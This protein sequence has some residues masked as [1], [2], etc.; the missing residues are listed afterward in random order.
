[1]RASAKKKAYA[2]I[3]LAATALWP[4]S[5]RGQHVQYSSPKPETDAASWAVLMCPL[6]TTIQES[7]AQPSDIQKAAD[8]KAAL[9]DR[10]RF[11]ISEFGP[12]SWGDTRF[13][14]RP[15]AAMQ[16][17][18]RIGKPA[19]KPLIVV[20]NDPDSWRRGEAADVLG[21]IGDPRA[22][23]PLL[24]VLG[25]DRIDS[26]RAAAARA[27]GHIP[28]RRTTALLLQALNAMDPAVRRE[29]ALALGR[30]KAREAIAPLTQR[31]GD[32]GWDGRLPMETVGEAAATAIAGYGETG[33]NLLLKALTSPTSRVRRDAIHGLASRKDTRVIPVFISLLQDPD[34]DVRY[35]VIYWLGEFKDRRALEPL[36]QLLPDKENNDEY[37]VTDAIKKI[38]GKPL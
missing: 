32:R 18:V 31:F 23:T 35:A 30:R 1:M 7:G 37:Q 20:L 29:A 15:E 26:V 9:A 13:D 21:E 38:E 25:T 28:G 6:S 33:Y 2:L 11:L 17:L 12:T 14:P 3:G 27:L 4:V 36:R 10:I 19:V 22:I 8:N 16:E 34:Y 5:A 24:S